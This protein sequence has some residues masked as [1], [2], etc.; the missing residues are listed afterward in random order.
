MS[1]RKQT[2][3]GLIW[4]FLDTF[5]VSGIYF[6]ATVYLTRILG[7]EKFGLIGM[8]SVF[9]AIGTALVDS[10]LSS[11]IIRTKDVDNRDFSTVFYLNLGTSIVLYV[12]F[13][14]AA[15]YIAEFYHKEVL[16]PII[17]LYCFSFVIAAFSAI[18]LAQLNREMR[19]KKI[20]QFNIPS[21]IFGVTIGIVLAFNGFGVW[22]FVW[23]QLARQFSLS[24][25]LWFFSH[26][27]PTLCFSKEKMKYHYGF[28]YKLMLSGLLYTFFENIYNIVIGKFYSVQSLGHF[29]RAR[30]FNNYP[31]SIITSVI[32]NVTYPLLAKIQ[33][34]PDKISKV[35]KQLIQ[36]SFAISAPLMLGAA[37]IAKP[38]FELVLGKEWIPAIFYFQII[39]LGSML[40]PIHSFNLNILKVYGKTNLLLK[41]EV[42]KK[43]TIVLGILISMPFGLIGL[44][45]SSVFVSFIYLIINTHYSKDLINYKT[46]DQVLDMIPI[47]S[48]A[49]IIAIFMF[50]FTYIL[51]NYS[52]YFQIIIPALVGIILY[53]GIHYVFK[54]RV[55]KIILELIGNYKQ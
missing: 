27:K 43:I 51:K 49:G 21:T 35:Y 44:I 19:F 8:I 32:G 20:L 26:W 48:I 11:S 16:V 7:P 25:L 3:F 6:I 39:C 24:A 47:F 30:T 46:K 23:M 42:Y 29:E 54:T 45:W 34:E 1:L 22:S 33:D 15:P 18:Q 31:I 5:F 14:F 55:M 41:L 52:L 17:R 28:G 37:A 53:V 2:F 13:Y 40:L 50:A 36:V 12:L 4:T 10:G 9:V 38:L